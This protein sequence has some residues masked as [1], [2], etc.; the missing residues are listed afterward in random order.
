MVSKVWIEK[1]TPLPKNYEGYSF[2]SYETVPLPTEKLKAYEILQMRD[3]AFINYHT[4]ENFL[5]LIKKKFG[6]KAVNNI[7]DMTKIKLKR[8]IIEENLNAN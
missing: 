7:L 2:H 4:N 8:K 6:P 3:D 5:N 1:N